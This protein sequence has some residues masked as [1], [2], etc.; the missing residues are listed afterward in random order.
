MIS[1]IYLDLDDVCADFTLYALQQVGCSSILHPRD[2]RMYNPQWGYDIIR[3]ANELHLNLEFTYDSFWE[4]IDRSIWSNVPE[5]TEFK[6]LLGFCR[7]LV[8][9]PNICILTSSI[10][11][12]DCAAG[13]VEWIQAHMPEK[14]KCQYLIGPPKHLLAQPNAL[15]IDDREEN[16]NLFKAH[17]GH[18]IL[19]PR[20]WNKLHSITEDWL[21]Y[22]F[23][24]ALQHTSTQ[25][26]AV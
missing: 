23:G 21:T 25:K 18:A 20:P 3:A 22:V 6:P 9:E 10:I 1:Q 26:V 11:G 15:L 4:Q 13:K 8:G 14:M 5:S 12:P 19:F 16:V 17:D 2:F 24:V 7:A